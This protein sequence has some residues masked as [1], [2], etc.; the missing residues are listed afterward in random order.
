MNKFIV[1]TTINDET[2][3]IK[4]FARFKDWHL[5]LV[6]DKKSKK[7]KS[8]ENLTFLSVEDQKK[9]GFKL[10]ETLPYNHYARKNIGYLYAIKNGAELIYDTDDDNIPYKNWKFPKFESKKILCCQKKFLNIYDKFT[11]EKVWP[12][13]FPL[14]EI[15]RKIISTNKDKDVEVGVWQGL[16]DHEPDV[17]AIF[18]LTVGK[19]IN[20]DKKDPIVLDENVYCPFNSQN[21]LWKKEVFPFLYFP[22]TVSFRFTDI[23]RGYITQ[24]LLWQANFNLGFT[25][26][27]VYQ[28][29]NEHDFMKDFQDEVEVYLNV[30]PIV[31]ILE[32]LKLGEDYLENLDRAYVE[33]EKNNYVKKEEVLMARSWIGDFKKLY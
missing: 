33:L 18:R 11:S 32:D 8:R 31:E 23:L 29:R 2:K 27:T 7:I 24:R 15:N 25:Q 14:D 6:G 3:A 22:S 28:E 19:Q 26:A 10:M 17:D 5:I 9:L 4:E 16:A 30:K 12:R 1:I 21:T 13:G 20:F